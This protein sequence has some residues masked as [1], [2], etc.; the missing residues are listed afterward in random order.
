MFDHN[1][2]TVFV[3]QRV[4]EVQAVVDGV[5]VHQVGTHLSFAHQKRLDNL[6]QHKSAFFLVVLS[7]FELT[8]EVLENGISV[9]YIQVL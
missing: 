9:G 5:S 3:E 6:Y 1:S 8:S 4:V 7:L 2:E